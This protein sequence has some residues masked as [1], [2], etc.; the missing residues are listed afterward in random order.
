MTIWEIN[1]K[2]F[3]AVAKKAALALRKGKV[4]ACPTDTVY[5]LLTDATNKK[6]VERV[7]LIKGR[8]KTKPLPIFVSNIAMA[9]RL[10]K[11]SRGQE[12]FLKKSWPGKVTVV[13]KSKRILPAETGTTESIALR[14][15]KHSLARLILGKV[16]RPLT[17]TSANLSGTPSLSDSKEIIAQFQNRKH[18][19]DMVLDAGVLPKSKPSKVID[20]TGVKHKVLRK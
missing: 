16:R 8:E 11:V 1:S 2:N 13:L 7:L 12:R 3:E 15:P 6:A 19:P 10:A 17:G 18:K 20:I 9:K 5:G 14:I 4:L